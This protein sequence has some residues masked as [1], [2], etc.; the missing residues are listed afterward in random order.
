MKTLFKAEFVRYRHWAFLCLLAQLSMFVFFAKLKP[1]IEPLNDELTLIIIIL[2]FGFGALQMLLHK[3]KNQWAFLLQRPLPQGQIYVALACA[4]LVNVIIAVPLGWLINV[5][6][7]ELFTGTIIDARH[8][9]FG[10]F[11]AAIG[12][13][14]Y[15]IGNLVALNA[16]KAAILSGVGLFVFL[17]NLSEYLWLQTAAALLIIAYLFYLNKASFKPDLLLPLKRERAITLFIIPMQMMLVVMLVTLAQVMYHVPNYLLNDKQTSESKADNWTELLA[18]DKVAYLLKDS[19]LVNKESL[20]RQAQLAD[21]DVINIH[22][23]SFSKPGQYPFRDEHYTLV[24]EENNNIWIFSHD[25]MLLQGVNINTREVIGWIGKSGFLTE[26]DSVVEQDTFEGVPFM[27]E[28]RFIATKQQIFEVDFDANELYL[29]VTLD[30]HEQLIGAPSFKSQYIALVTTTHIYLYDSLTFY[31][32]Y[33]EQT[34]AY[35]LVHPSPLNQMDSVTSYVMV[36]GFLLVYQGLE[37]HGFDAPGAEIIYA[38][39]DGNISSLY[40]Y[41]AKAHQYPAVVRHI[42]YVVSPLLHIVDASINHALRAYPQQKQPL[43]LIISGAMPTSIYVIAIFIQAL[44]LCIIVYVI[45]RFKV[46]SG[47]SLLWRI[48]VG[49]IG[50]PALLSFFLIYKMKDQYKPVANPI[51]SPKEPPSPLKLVD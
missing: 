39:R 9:T 13:I 44:C 41:H 29:K 47:I 21:N 2:C 16:S 46:T 30:E 15:L 17:Q 19:D 32:Q 37:Y 49:A 45:G 6:A 38:Q 10:L 7:F 3:R 42:N 36:D 25:L 18:P 40:K 43:Y 48:V 11:L 33:G 12:S 4:G 50:L 1:V 14:S 34:P 5:L 24:D 8:Y 20:G 35:S 31:S 28:N 22:T 23:R 27:L 26:L 51:P